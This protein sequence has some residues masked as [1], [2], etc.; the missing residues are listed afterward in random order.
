MKDKATI[1]T[2]IKVKEALRAEISAQ[3]KYLSKEDAEDWRGK[4]LEQRWERVDAEILILKWVL[5]E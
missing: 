4:R 1:E 3:Y 5:N 2:E